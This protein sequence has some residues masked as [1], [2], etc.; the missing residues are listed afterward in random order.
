[1]LLVCIGL[2]GLT[3]QQSD[4]VSVWNSSS[5]VYKGF[6]KR[7]CGLDQVF[8]WTKCG[9]GLGFGNPKLRVTFLLYT[10][11]SRRTLHLA[12]SIPHGLWEEGHAGWRSSFLWIWSQHNRHKDCAESFLQCNRGSEDRGASLDRKIVSSF[13]YTWEG[14]CILFLSLVLWYFPVK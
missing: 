12:D 6:V 9:P 2:M 13:P 7:V 8:P 11:D 4:M 14:G 5:W 10:G 1:M 3:G